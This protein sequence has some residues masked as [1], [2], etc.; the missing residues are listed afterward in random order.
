MDLHYYTLR[1]L[2]RCLIVRTTVHETKT[3]RNVSNEHEE[4]VLCAF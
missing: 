3:Y 4:F 2:L 1:P